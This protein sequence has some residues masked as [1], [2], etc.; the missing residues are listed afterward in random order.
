MEMIV[1]VAQQG[2]IF[3][4]AV[5]LQ[6]AMLWL[7]VTTSVV[8]ALSA[9]FYRSRAYGYLVAAFE[10]AIIGAEIV[11]AAIWALPFWNALFIVGALLMV[12][13]VAT[14]RQRR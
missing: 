11:K 9:Q 8:A 12:V 6:L 4:G 2:L 10:A 13:L 14:R 3:F 1:A 7:V 5:A